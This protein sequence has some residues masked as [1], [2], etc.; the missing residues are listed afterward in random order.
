M[1]LLSRF[2][3]VFRGQR[4]DKELDDEL[5]FHVEERAEDLIRRGWS[6]DDARREARKIVGN[7]LLL[8]ESS[9]DIKLIPWLES[10][11]QDTRFGLRILWKRRTAT[12]AAVLSLSIAIGACTA[13]FSLLDALVLR[14]LPLPHPEQLVYLSYPGRNTTDSYFS[15]S[16]FTKLRDVSKGDVDLFGMTFGGGLVPV[17]FGGAHGEIE[18]VRLQS[19]TGNAFSVLGVKPALGR[20]LTAEDDAPTNRDAAVLS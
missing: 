5:L 17:V 4:L 20:L 13:A 10:I 3:N 7:P 19:I 2:V 14:P 6:Q 8:R 15:Y 1:S 16:L 12:A 11:V 9:R 18:R